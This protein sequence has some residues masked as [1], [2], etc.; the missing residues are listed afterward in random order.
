MHLT[1]LDHFFWG[2]GFVAN[3]VLLLVLWYRRRWHTFPFFASALALTVTRTVGLYLINTFGNGRQYSVAYW[4][5]AV[6]DTFLQLGVIFELASKVFRPLNT[7]LPDVRGLLGWL[8]GL[9]VLGASCL[10]WLASPPARTPIEAFATRGNLFAAALMSELFL[11]M[12]VVSLT[13]GLPWRSHAGAIAQGLGGYSL[14]SVVIEAGHAYFGVGREA[15]AFVLLSQIR[16]VAYLGCVLYW[17]VNL[18]SDEQSARTMTG[19]MRA[20]L[21]TLQTQVAGDLRTV[22]FRKSK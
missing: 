10:T 9:S 4:S 6:V 7:W 14:I 8:A 13:A 2:A 19:E 3:A 20:D 16:M 1:P 15:A 12:M 17:V 22:K 5:L 11:S 21:L 18:N